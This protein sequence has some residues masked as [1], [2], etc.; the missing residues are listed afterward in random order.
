[1]IG[2]LTFK[3]FRSH[4]IATVSRTVPIVITFKSQ[5][6]GYFLASHILRSTKNRRLA[7]QRSVSSE[8]QELSNLF[9]SRFHRF[10]MSRVSIIIAI[11]LF[12]SMLCG[13]ISSSH[14]SCYSAWSRCSE[15][16]SFGTGFAW[17]SCPDYCRR[18]KGYSSGACADTTQKC[19]WFTIKASQCQCFGSRVTP[20]PDLACKGGL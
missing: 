4:R 14:G 2:R 10:T 16:S 19:L 9:E 5:S 7:L 18:C 11:L 17:K 20:R 12:V 6:H 3:H 1:M 13:Q 8:K 15:W